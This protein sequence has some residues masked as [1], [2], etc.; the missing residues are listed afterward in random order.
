[1]QLAFDVLGEDVGLDVDAVAD[2][3][4]AEGGDGK[5]M[6]DERDAEAAGIDVD[7]READA[8]D[9]DGAFAGHLGE[10]RGRGQEPH[11]APVGIVFAGVDRGESVD[12]AG[13]V[14]AADGVARAKLLFEVDRRTGPELAQVGSRE[15]FF[16]GLKGE[17]TRGDVDDRETAAVDRDAVAE[18]CRCGDRRSANDE[19]NAWGF[20]HNVDNFRK[21][22]DE[23]GEHEG[24]SGSSLTRQLSG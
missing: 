7:Q 16:A 5:G 18:S 3:A 23:A 13:D 10:L 11:F 15:C 4:V 19:P 6:R 17:F 12:V 22:L 21:T 8:I 20:G 1:L 24:R 2:L 14:V 9:G